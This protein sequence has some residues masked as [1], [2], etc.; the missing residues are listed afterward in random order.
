MARKRPEQNRFIEQPELPQETSAEMLPDGQLYELDSY[1]NIWVLN[2]KLTG[3]RAVTINQAYFQNVII[4][5]TH[6]TRFDLTDTRF[7]KCDFA[8][9][10]W[11]K[12]SLNKVELIGSMRCESFLLPNIG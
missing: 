11:D 2:C 4:S 8:N 7:D 12:A 10:E 1:K 9:T 5:D 3:A 6:F